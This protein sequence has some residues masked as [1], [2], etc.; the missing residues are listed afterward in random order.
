[1]SEENIDETIKRLETMYVDLSVKV[2][3][4]RT[5]IFNEQI[6]LVAGLKAEVSEAAKE[7][8]RTEVLRSDK[9]AESL[10]KYENYMVQYIQLLNSWRNVQDALPRMRK[11]RPS[12]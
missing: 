1:M 12:Q 8:N 11:L 7:L 3:D 2:D 5:I 6:G 9:L 10:N 4:F